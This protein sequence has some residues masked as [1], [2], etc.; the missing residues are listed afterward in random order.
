MKCLV[1]ELGNVVL[2][3]MRPYG[4]VSQSQFHMKSLGVRSEVV[5]YMNKN[6]KCLEKIPNIHRKIARNFLRLLAIETAF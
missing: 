2:L 6:L 1:F 5:E 4:S 3:F